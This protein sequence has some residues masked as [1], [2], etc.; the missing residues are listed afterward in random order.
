MTTALCIPIFQLPNVTLL[1]DTYY[2][3]WA[4][5]AAMHLD[6]A[7][8]WEA[9]NRTETKPEATDT[10]ATA[11]YSRKQKYGKSL[12]LSMVSLEKKTII[13]QAATATEAW[14]SLADTL[15]RKD[16]ISTFHVFNSVLDLN[17]DESS[18][19]LDHILIFESAWNRLVQK[20]SFITATDKKYLQSLIMCTEDVKLK[21]QLLLRTYRQSSPTLFENLS[22]QK[23][24]TYN[25]VRTRLLDNSA[26][27]DGNGNALFSASKP[28]KQNKGKSSSKKN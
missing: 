12:L 8:V 16:V 11:N 23:D 15:D 4:P 7:D 5:E 14:K 6:T 10:V 28:K 1:V 9:I 20:L 17:K 13:T 18:T 26:P 21:A 27:S 19:M 25:D 22:T 24:L 2:H 3:V